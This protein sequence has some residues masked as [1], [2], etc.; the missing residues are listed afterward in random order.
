MTAPYSTNTP[1]QHQEQGI[2]ELI[3]EITGDLSRLFQQEVELAKAEMKIEAKKAGKM[4]A[5]FGAAG[6]AGVMVLILVSFAIVYALDA[7]MPQ[8]WAALI[9]A[10]VWAAI[11]AA[12]Y[13]SA[14]K[15]AAAVD[16]VPHQTVE[17]L[18]EDKEWL[19]NPTTR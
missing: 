12:L 19:R 10:V 8:G 15:Q 13:F 9:V 11:G 3:S 4:G 5:M 14:R 6:L 2:G 17:T 16:P 1:G 18:K 7:V